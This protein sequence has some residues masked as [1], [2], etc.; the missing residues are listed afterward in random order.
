MMKGRKGSHSEEGKK[1]SKIL[2]KLYSFTRRGSVETVK[3]NEDDSAVDS[4]KEQM[5]KSSSSVQTIV[6]RAKVAKL[7]KAKTAHKLQRKVSKQKPD[8]DVFNDPFFQD[9]DFMDVG[10]SLDTVSNAIGGVTKLCAG[11]VANIVNHDNGD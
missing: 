10:V 5:S 11:G 9:D 1:G 6:P 7:K 4:C 3:Q 8:D 2:K